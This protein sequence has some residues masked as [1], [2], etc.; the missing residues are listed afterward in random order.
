MDTHKH[1]TYIQTLFGFDASKRRGVVKWDQALDT[2]R[3]NLSIHTKFKVSSSKDMSGRSTI[4][5]SFWCLD[6]K[7]CSHT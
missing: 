2:P 1:K 4:V 5:V 3:V 6:R 7:G